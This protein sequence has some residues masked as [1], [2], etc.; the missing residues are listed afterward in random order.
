MEPVNRRSANREQGQATV[1]FALIFPALILIVTGIIEFGLTFNYWIGMN[2]NAQNA[3]R[4]VAV[5]RVP[6]SPAV[7]PYPA[8]TTPVITPDAQ[9]YKKYIYTQIPSVGLRDE[10]A[11]VQ[12]AGRDLS[13]IQI[14]FTPAATPTAT[15]AQIGDAVTVTIKSPNHKISLPFIPGGIPAGLTGKATMRIEKAPSNSIPK[16]T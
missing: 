2:H 14:C 4:Y 12:G 15:T 5:D 9:D 10:I 16:C 3:A 8:V 7:D 6:E 13:N 1:E 11:P